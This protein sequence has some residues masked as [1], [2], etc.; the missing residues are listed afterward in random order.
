MY[1]QANN[2][3]LLN[4]NLLP[5]LFS[6]EPFLYLASAR[7]SLLV[8]AH[9]VDPVEVLFVLAFVAHYSRGADGGFGNH[10]VEH[11]PV[12]VFLLQVAHAALLHAVAHTDVHTSRAENAMNLSKHLVCVGARTVSTKY[13]VEGALVNYSVEG[14]VLK[15]KLANIA[16]LVNESGVLFLIEFLH[17]LD[18]SKGNVNVDNVLESVVKHFFGDA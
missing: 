10:V 4:L 14:A 6:R 8:L 3:H 11:S 15:L 16:L 12:V 7:S 9:D 1:T 2:C 5:S 18:N 13:R 17:L